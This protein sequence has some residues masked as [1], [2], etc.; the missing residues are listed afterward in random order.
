[1]M[2]HQ[3]RRALGRLARAEG[4][5]LVSLLGGALVTCGWHPNAPA[6]PLERCH[7]VPCSC[8]STTWRRLHRTSASSGVAH[9]GDGRG[10]SA[11]TLTLP[12][13]AASPLGSLAARIDPR[14]LP[15]AEAGSPAA[16]AAAA[17]A[18][19]RPPAAA[20]AYPC[21][22]VLRMSDLCSCHWCRTA[23]M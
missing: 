9:D 4:P 11:L 16:A 19:R 1:M 18:H 20:A 17:A 3:A 8:P 12:G 23:V 6:T 2:L 15:L 10:F 5:Q 21:G 22:G 14:W 7:I 13:C